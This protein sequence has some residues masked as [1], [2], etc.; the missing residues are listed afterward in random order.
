MFWHF[1]THYK[2]SR[3]L[4]RQK[5][6]KK[7]EDIVR[8]EKNMPAQE[9]GNLSSSFWWAQVWAKCHASKTTTSSYPV[10]SCLDFTNNLLECFWVSRQTY[11]VPKF[12]CPKNF[13]IFSGS[14]VAPTALQIKLKFLSRPYPIF[15]GL[16]LPSL[17]PTSSHLLPNPLAMQKYLSFCSN[18][19]NSIFPT[20]SYFK[21]LSSG[22]IHLNGC[23]S[24]E[25]FLTPSSGFGTILC[26]MVALSVL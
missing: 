18:S 1:N 16:T 23:L 5:M 7:Q 11:Q 21:W 26:Y 22:L 20:D 8:W 12:L 9:L 13:L 4:E 24:Q 2:S 19:Q 17:S 6:P 3:I 15:Q 14:S 10:V 25:V